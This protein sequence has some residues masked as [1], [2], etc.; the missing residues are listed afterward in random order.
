M[1]NNFVCPCCNSKKTKKFLNAKKFPYFTTPITTKVKKKIKNKM[2]NKYFDDLKYNFCKICNHIFLI[3]LPNIKIINELY[4]KYYSYPSAILGEFTPSRDDNFLNFF[5]T[6]LRK[7]KALN[8][9]LFYEIGCYDGYILYHL[10]KLGFKNVSGCDPSRG[11]NIAKKFGIRVDK[12]FFDVN[13]PKFKKNK[14]DYIISR[15]LL[16]HLEKP[17]KFLN[18]IEKITNENSRIFIEV[19]NGDFYLKNGLVEAFSH[20]HIHLYNK[21]SMHKLIK[22][23][24]LSI[25]FIKEEEANIYFILSYK[26]NFKKI[27]KKNL[28]KKFLSNY[29]KKKNQIQSIIKKFQ[30]KK[31]I[32][33]GAGGFS[34]AAIHLYKINKN[35]VYKIL[36]SDSKK[37]GNQFLDLDISVQNNQQFFGKNSLIIITSYYTNDILKLIIKKKLSENIMTIHP[38]VKLKKIK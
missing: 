2:F 10:Q 14:C 28:I 5:K 6:Y 1:Q 37:V 22:K 8:S 19:P 33:Y 29:E 26:N 35:N 9:E 7:K 30:N 20:Q 27:K 32:F 21:Y 36:D 23:T 18:D 25:D 11:A 3:K 38:N 13:L 31:I 12:V 24:N 17:E 4:E 34:C 15:H 16:E